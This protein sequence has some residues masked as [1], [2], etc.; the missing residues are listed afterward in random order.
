MLLSTDPRMPAYLAAQ[1]RS[2]SMDWAGAHHLML[3]L[4]CEW[5]CQLASHIALGSS[6]LRDAHP[7]EFWSC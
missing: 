4:M 1:C 3:I 5:L 6:P 2:R 7:I